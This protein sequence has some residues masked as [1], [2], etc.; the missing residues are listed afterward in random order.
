MFLK[1]ALRINGMKK[2]GRW[3]IVISRGSNVQIVTK[4]GK[5]QKR[6][7]IKKLEAFKDRVPKTKL[8]RWTL[9]RKLYKLE[10]R[11]MVHGPNFGFQSEN[12]QN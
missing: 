4:I 1:R 2:A 3:K 5:V 11:I 7:S 12:E 6:A 8:S 10:L 9:F